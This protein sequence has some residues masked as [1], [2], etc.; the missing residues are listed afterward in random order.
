MERR[1]YLMGK[2]VQRGEALAS[3]AAYLLGR[4]RVL[5][6]KPQ[7][8]GTQFRDTSDGKTEPYPIGNASGLEQTRRRVGLPAMRA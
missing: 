7:V 3:N 8:C 1:L 5:G 4:F 2:A 6:G